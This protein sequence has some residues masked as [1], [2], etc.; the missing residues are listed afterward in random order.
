MPDQGGLWQPYPV[1]YKRGAPKV[2]D[3]DRL[4]LCAQAMCL[5]EMLCCDIPEGALFYG[6][7]RRREV[8]DLDQV[9]RSQVRKLLDEM[10]ALYHRSHTPK[11][12]PTRGCNACSLRDLCLPKLAKKCNVADYLR[13]SMEDT[14]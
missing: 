2:T 3:A 6:E 9:L 11:V 13:K 8:V 4:Q 7:I 10:H 12:K 14:L 5:E 1:E